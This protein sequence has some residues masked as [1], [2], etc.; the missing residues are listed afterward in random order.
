MV[1]RKRQNQ[2]DIL[3]C[4]RCNCEINDRRPLG[5]SPIWY[6]GKCKRIIEIEHN[7]KQYRKNHPKK[8]T[9]KELILKILRKKPATT[10][11]LI[12]ITKTKNM[13]TLKQFITQLRA[14]GYNI[15]VKHYMPSHY[16][17]VKTP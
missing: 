17:L 2:P 7:S 16:V 12:R 11:E 15:Q 5:F 4:R 10:S 13:A 1:G 9:K 8:V 3:I 6:C 14:N